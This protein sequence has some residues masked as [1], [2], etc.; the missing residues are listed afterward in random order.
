MIASRRR[1]TAGSGVLWVE[2]PL[3]ALG[4]IEDY[5]WVRMFALAGTPAEVVA[6]I[7]TEVNRILK[8]SDFHVRLAGVGFEPVGGSAPEAAAYLKS[9]LAKWARV[10]R[11]TGAKAE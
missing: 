11:E 8:A 6:K 10:V 1:I 7:N 2:R 9:E 5:T 3:A 4:P